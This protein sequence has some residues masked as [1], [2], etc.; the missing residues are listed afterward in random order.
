[1]LIDAARR[2]DGAQELLDARPEGGQGAEEAR[3]DARRR[4]AAHVQKDPPYALRSAAGAR[5]EFLP[6]PYCI[7]AGERGIAI[8][9]GSYAK[10]WPTLKLQLDCE[11]LV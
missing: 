2:V 5:Y 3:R 11:L 1:M 4:L 6:V 8:T 7:A 9:S 10:S